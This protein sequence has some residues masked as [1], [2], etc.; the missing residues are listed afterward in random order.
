LAPHAA[1]REATR[2][3]ARVAPRSRIVVAVDAEASDLSLEIAR[4]LLRDATTELVGL[5]VEDR[6][7]FEHATAALARE[8]AYTGHARTFERPKL[9]GQ[10]RARAAEARRR[11]EASAARLAL[12]HDFQV[13]RGDIVAELV[14]EAASAEALV[15][16]FTA[17]AAAASAWSARTLRD[18]LTAPVPA[19]LVAREGWLTG[20]G[21]VAVL[22]KGVDARVLDA[23]VRLARRSRS[24]LTVLLA[25]ET[26]SERRDLKESLHGRLAAADIELRGVLA[27]ADMKQETILG[28]ARGARVLVL[29][30]RHAIDDAE[31]VLQ[32]AA[33]THLPLLLVDSSSPSDFQEAIGG[34]H[35]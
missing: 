17:A 31:L 11:F 35:G 25:A 6:R 24:P 7:L 21:V 10:L 26:E 28:A 13:L 29:A 2:V 34:S 32:L 1:P 9:E 4:H 8:V 5:F 12:A 19:L 15:V 30:N 22:A 27:F 14:R 3:S 16:G 18:L 33:H 20:R 23:S